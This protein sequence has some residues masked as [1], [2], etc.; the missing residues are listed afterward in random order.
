MEIISVNS[1]LWKY[2]ADKF[3]KYPIYIRITGARKPTYQ[4]S[5]YSCKLEDWDERTGGLKFNLPNAMLINANLKKQIKTLEAAI[6]ALRLD[7]KSFTV[8]Q[9]IALS[10]D[11]GPEFDFYKFSQDAAEK[12]EDKFSSETLRQFECEISKMKQHKEVV[13]ITDITEDFLVDYEHWM[14]TVRKNT[15]NTVW[16]SMKFVRRMMNAAK[17]KK[18]ITEDQ[19]PF[20]EDKFRFGYIQPLRLHL[21]ME[22]VKSIENILPSQPVWIANVG[23]SFVL[24]CYC[25]LRFGDSIIFDYEKHV[26]DGRLILRAGKGNQV[27]SIKVHS[28]LKNAMNHV[29][30][31]EGTPLTNQ[32][33]N[34]HIK[35]IAEAALIHQKVTFHTAR[36]TFA[37]ECANQGIPIEVVQ[38][39]LGHTKLETTKIYYD[40]INPVI[41]KEMDKWDNPVTKKR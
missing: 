14:R 7:N 36:H 4:K 9:A 22:E 18:I 25:G 13:N 28:R 39:L 37:I 5:G 33:A 29:R 8:T 23:W 3:G 16:K 30:Q 1:I 6:L 21:T 17:K 12:L 10:N 15:T 34:R 31:I 40:I 2:R 35:T 19:Y 11:K 20:G 41:D 27:I 32:S 24:C 26:V 38:K